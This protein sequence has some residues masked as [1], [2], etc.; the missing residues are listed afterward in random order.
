M[1]YQNGFSV[2]I[3]KEIV[4]ESVVTSFVVVAERE[5]VY[6]VMI[7]IFFIWVITKLISN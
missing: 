2:Y 7:Y 3:T 4:Y 6:Y 1:I 5:V